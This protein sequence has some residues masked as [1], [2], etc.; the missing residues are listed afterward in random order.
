[1]IKLDG[2]SAFVA[3]VWWTW[4]PKATMPPFVTRLFVTLGSWS[5]RWRTRPGPPVAHSPECQR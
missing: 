4:L 2:I 5:S 3:V 1:M